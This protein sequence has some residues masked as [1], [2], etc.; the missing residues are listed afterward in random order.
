MKWTWWSVGLVLATVTACGRGEPESPME[1]MTA[2]EH[3]RMLAGGTQGAMDS[4]GTA[5][6]QPVHLTAAQERALGVVYGVVEYE[7]VTRTIRTVGTIQAPETGLH[8]VTTKLEGFVEQLNVS[9][10]GQMVRRGDPLLTLY[11]P[12]V[13]AAQEELLSARRLLTALAGTTGPQVEQAREL[14]EA[15]R[16][17]LLWWDLP[18]DWIAGI[19]ASG[20]AERTVRLRAP[21]TGVVIE[22]MVVPGQ[23]IMPGMPLYQLADL[24]EVWIEGEVFEQDLRFVQLGAEAHVEVSAY[25][26]EHLMARVSFIYPTLEA[27][28]RTN[29]V[30]LTLPNPGQRLKPGMFATIYVDVSLGRALMVPM[31]AVVITGERNLVFVRGA[32]GMLVPRPVVLGVRSEGRVQILEGLEAGETIVR[33]ANFLIDAESRLGDTGGEMPGMQHGAPQAVPPA[34]PPAEHRHD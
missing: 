7:Q 32:D 15:A 27:T 16:R 17:R 5:I 1:G 31:S 10:T 28:S 12:A 29:R 18:A 30:R 19:E 22:R 13:V 26:A 6:R 8:E 14:V 34:A 20:R 2:E 25:P 24:S 21:A 4:L 11:S 23:R 33:S 3:A 9:S